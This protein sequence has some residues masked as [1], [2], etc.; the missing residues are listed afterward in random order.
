MLGILFFASSIKDCPPSSQITKVILGLAAGGF[1]AGLT[2]AITTK[3]IGATATGG[4]AICIIVLFFPVD[5][6]DIFNIEHFPNC[7]G[8]NLT[9][10]PI[11]PADALRN[12]I[13]T[14]NNLEAKKIIEN[15]LSPN[16]GLDEVGNNSLHLAAK[17]GNLALTNWFISK[18]ADEIKPNDEGK[19]AFELIPSNSANKSNL[20]Q[21]LVTQHMRLHLYDSCMANGGSDRF[22]NNCRDHLKNGDP[23]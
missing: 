22:T 11:E 13:M 12:A 4:L 15:G 7:P 14:K 1:A 2:G 23:R 18:G 21:A 20:G 6:K 17:T 5:S 19:Y 10:P 3:R 8:N 16:F 9:H